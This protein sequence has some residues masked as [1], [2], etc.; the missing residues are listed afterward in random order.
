[1][2]DDTV[3]LSLIGQ[4]LRRR[5][6]LLAAIALLGALVG[7]GASVLFSPGYSTSTR[8]LLQG[9]REPD[10]LVTEAQVAMSSTV[11]DRT[12][13]ALGWNVS[14]VEL[15]SS[16]TAEVANGNVIEIF[17]EADT[18]DKAKKLADQ[19][20]EEYV[21]FSAQL[22]SNTADAS[23][24]VFQEQRETL[25]RLVAETSD[26]I[27]QLHDSATKGVTVESVQVRTELEGLRTTLS[28]AMTKLDQAD[29]ASS[30]ANL[31]IM[32]P[33]ERP[34][35]AAAPTMTHFVVGCAV[36][37][38]LVGLLGH[39]IARRA[40]KR[41]RNESEIASALG[42][43]VL[44]SVDVPYAPPHTG[45]ATTA[46]GRRR[47]LPRWLVP[48]GRP[49]DITELPVSDDLARGT[50]YR[51]VL[52]RIHGEAGQ[53]LRVMV[54]VT[55]DDE[56]AHDAVARLAVAASAAG[57]TSVVTDRAHFAD[58]VARAGAPDTPG[59]L[60]I[61]SSTG[62]APVAYRTM[63]RVQTVAVARPTVP[64]EPDLSG[65]IVV[66]TTG[67]RTAWELVGISQA[68][69]DAELDV[70][71]VVIAH[72]AKPLPEKESRPEVSADEP[73]EA[74]VGSA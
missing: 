52:P 58:L 61:R 50:R 9:P 67:T 1:M 34:T 39:L 56:S 65:A 29:F 57:P 53:P 4:I 51:R 18:P 69:A 74:M 38:F 63:L 49:W 16:V 15:Q 42:T 55:E 2:S 19:V 35:G 47:W 48:D 13:S 24:Q 26:R 46:T 20:A 21:R 3:R 37:F 70:L 45:S 41:L 23:A 60:I 71:G 32:S 72:R 22:V 12:A 25:R 73:A 40:D 28:Q 59:Q 31:V 54:L 7:A 33:A 6:R 11:L 17:G 8:V 10:E 14:G 27:T 64:D 30:R 68:C 43:T 62:P 44:S 36:L 66:L 5:W